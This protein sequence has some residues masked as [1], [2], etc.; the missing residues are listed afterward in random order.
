MHRK[1]NQQQDGANKVDGVEQ[2]FVH[3]LCPVGIEERADEQGASADANGVSK[4]SVH[5]CV[6]SCSSI[7]SK[8][9]KLVATGLIS[10]TIRPPLVT[11]PATAKLIAMR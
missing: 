6:P 11:P 4:C 1:R 10:S 3:V 5:A 9:G 7:A 8:P 2:Q